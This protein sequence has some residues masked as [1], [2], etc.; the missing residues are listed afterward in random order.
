MIADTIERDL[1]A[2]RTVFV[3]PTETDNY[4]RA[5]LGRK[6][7]SGRYQVTIHRARLGSWTITLPVERIFLC[8]PAGGHVL[9]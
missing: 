1:C 4:R 9:P 5:T 3:L 2:G 6:L 8:L 7:P